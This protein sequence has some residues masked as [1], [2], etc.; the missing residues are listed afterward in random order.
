MFLFYARQSEPNPIMI[1]TLYVNLVV[2]NV[3]ANVM[4]NLVITSFTV[5]VKWNAP[6]FD[7]ER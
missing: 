6:S 2:S 4:F 1:D 7:Y 5:S 3:E